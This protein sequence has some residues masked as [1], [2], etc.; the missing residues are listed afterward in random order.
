MRTLRGFVASILLLVFFTPNS[1]QAQQKD[2]RKVDITVDITDSKNGQGG[3]IKVSTKESQ[4]EFMLHL[5]G[6]GKNNHNNDKFSITT[7]TI[8]NIPP[9][10]YDL[11]I[12]YPEGNFCQETRKVTVN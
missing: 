10:T 1:T 5:V 4:V 9:G 6:K 11:V 12:H 3:A 7:G 2:C 8:E